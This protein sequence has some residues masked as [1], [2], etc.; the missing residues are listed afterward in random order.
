MESLKGFIEFLASYPAWAKLL[1]LSGLIITIGTLVFA[2]RNKDAP[3]A[4]PTG[5]V[6]LRITGVTL[7]PHDSDAEV[8][9]FAYVNDTRFQYPSLAGV[10]W[11]KVGPAMSSQRFTLPKAARYEIRFEMN[12][13]TP[14][15][16]R[17]TTRE[18][19]A[20]G[21]GEASA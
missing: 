8:Q 14:G 1:A 3:D 2:P 15:G 12:L 11:L 19:G 10:S 4:A 18:P 9:V 21:R 6:A 13:K 7:F 17:P 20:S 5:D 16:R